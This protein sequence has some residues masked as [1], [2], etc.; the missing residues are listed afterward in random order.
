MNKTFFR[1]TVSFLAVL[2]VSFLILVAGEYVRTHKT[3]DE[4]EART[5]TVDETF[6]SYSGCITASGEPC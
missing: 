2:A 4:E 1:N 3:P 5:I 6:Q